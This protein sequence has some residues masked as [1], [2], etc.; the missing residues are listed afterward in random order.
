V[1][2]ASLWPFV[3]AALAFRLL[4]GL[5]STFWSE[6]ERQVYL[7][8]LRAFARGEWPWFGAD[9][10]WTGGQLPGA[11][12]GLLVGGPLALWPVPEAPFVLLNVLSAGTL[13]LLAWYCTRRYPDLPAWLVWGSLFT[14]PW[15]LNFSTQIINT[16][17]ILPGAV[18][19]FVGFF[20]A[21]PTLRAG[22]LRS[23]IAWALM[24]AGLL[25]LVQIHMS[26][27]LLPPYVL[28]AALDTLR[29]EPRRIATRMLAFAAGAAVPGSLLLPTLVRFGPWAGGVDRVI[30]LHPQPVSAFLE[31]VAR[32]LSFTAFETN[33]F[34]GLHTGERLLFLWRQPWV[35]PFV[36]LTTL[37]GLAQPIAMAIA[38]FLPADRSA[39]WRRIRRL[40]AATLLWIYASFF[41]SVRGPLAHAFY[42]VLP[43]A[44][45]YACCCWRAYGSPRL[46]RVAAVTLAAGL[47][48][49]AGLFLDRLPRRSLY[50]DRPLVQAAIS[51]GNDRFLGDRRDSLQ[52]AHDPRPRAI[53]PVPDV[54]AYL[55]AEATTDLEV[56]SVTWS[57][58]IRGRVSRL[59]VSVR[60]RSEAAA[61]LDIRY[62]ADYRGADG[63][64]VATR[65]G[66]IKVVLQPGSTRTWD[67]LTDGLAPAGATNATL[68]IVGAEKCIPATTTSAPD[69]ASA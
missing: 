4:A 48:M 68:R 58:V 18:V 13:A 10:V 21:T 27:V 19:F 8:G 6:D 45:L 43:V 55:Q 38:G 69:R 22:L 63:R 61:W 30:E 44:V 50:V 34:L 23:S 3:L 51:A 37:V 67:D 41:F 12:Q 66:I 64:V 31:I 59:I 60:N 33:R 24:G 1:R 14:L 46:A 32:F 49:H 7:I 40:V 15:T 52:E 56:T 26:W 47:V 36:A 11:L 16:S 54:N 62:V 28:F 42:A 25:T 39:E 35:V 5:S 2:H 9:V 20:E 17:Y 29:R 57:P 65:E 53:D